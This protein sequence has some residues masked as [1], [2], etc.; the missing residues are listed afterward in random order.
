M[1]EPVARESF[2][3]YHKWLGI[4]PRDQPPHYYRLL[5]IDLFESDEDV[6]SA[7]ADKQMAF[8]RSFQTG[9]DAQLSQ[10]ILNE[11]STARVCLLNAVK[12]AQYDAASPRAWRERRP[13]SKKP[14]RFARLPQPPQTKRWKLA[15]NRPMRT[16]TSRFRCNWAGASDL[17]PAGRNQKRPPSCPWW[18]WARCWSSAWLRLPWSCRRSRRPNC[19]RRRKIPMATGPGMRNPPPLNRPARRASCQR[20]RIL[21]SRRRPTPLGQSAPTTAPMPHCLTSRRKPTPSTVLPELNRTIGRLAR[22]CRKQSVAAMIPPPA[23]RSPRRRRTRLPS[24]PKPRRPKTPEEL[25]KQL[26]DA[27]TPEDYQAVAG[28]ALRA[29]GKAMDDQQ[30]DAAKQLI[31]KSLLAARK[32]GDSKLIVKATRALTRPE[33]VKEILAEKDKQDE[34]STAASR[35][36]RDLSPPLRN[37]AGGTSNES[38]ETSGQQAPAVPVT[39][40]VALFGTNK[41]G[42]SDWSRPP[43]YAD[44][45]AI[46]RR[47]VG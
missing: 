41:L 31:L 44:H 17:K 15:P 22:S 1:T 8:I 18:L 16:F 2:D 6:I 7:A 13:A 39:K 27:K 35:S 33:S 12:K 14:S 36:P 34:D 26:A 25:D 43:G 29:A 21:E 46:R 3:P 42:A 38:P 45:P 11:I 20:R 32:S 40:R 5:A 28:E 37:S 4:S 23:S 30:Q 24:R 10:K 9:K 19:R 47:H